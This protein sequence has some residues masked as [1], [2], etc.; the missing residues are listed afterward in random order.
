VFQQIWLP[1]V[2]AHLATPKS[3]VDTPIWKGQLP[4]VDL[5]WYTVRKWHHVNLKG[6]NLINV[7][8]SS[9]LHKA[10]S[11]YSTIYTEELEHVVNTENRYGLERVHRNCTTEWNEQFHGEPEDHATDKKTV[12]LSRRLTYTGQRLLPSRVQ[13]NSSE[14]TRR[15]A[16]CRRRIF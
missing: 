2:I 6:L 12:R 5:F 14:I 13:I 4:N 16:A 1:Q 15:R 9:S 8:S 11:T 10:S 3:R 7:T